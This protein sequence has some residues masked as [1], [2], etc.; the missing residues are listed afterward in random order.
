MCIRDSHIQQAL[1]ALPVGRLE[2]IDV[3]LRGRAGA[4]ARTPYC[5]VGL[6]T[7]G[8]ERKGWGT[9]RVR[10]TRGGAAPTGGSKRDGAG[11]A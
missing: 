9:E 5:E 6:D 10:A 11:P 1:H 8:W 7:D 3:P 4:R 2:P